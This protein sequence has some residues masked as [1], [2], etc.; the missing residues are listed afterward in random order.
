M[1]KKIEQYLEEKKSLVEQALRKCMPEPTGLAGEVIRSMH[2]S[3][4]A[5]GKRNKSGSR[6]FR[7]GTETSRKTG[8]GEKTLKK[9]EVPP[10]TTSKKDLST[11]NKNL[12]Y[13]PKTFNFNTEFKRLKRKVKHLEEKCIL[14]GWISGEEFFEITRKFQQL[15]FKASRTNQKNG[16]ENDT[17]KQRSL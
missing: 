6:S 11:N 14:D 17:Q 9:R 13:H 5:G 2:Y 10:L 8:L 4:F 1:S 12:R 7:T 15:M 3:L 16:N